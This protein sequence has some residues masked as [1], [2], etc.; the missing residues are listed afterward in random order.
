MLYRALRLLAA[1]NK[2]SLR[3]LTESVA[4]LQK[5]RRRLTDS[6]DL[7]LDN[8]PLR[9]GLNPIVRGLFERYERLG[10]LSDLNASVELRRKVIHLTPR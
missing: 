9:L 2:S 3:A 8:L 6:D 7:S 5:A 10:E 1:I 4:N